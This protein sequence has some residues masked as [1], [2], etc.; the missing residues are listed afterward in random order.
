MVIIMYNVFVYGSL[1]KGFGNHGFLSQSEFLGDATTVDSRFRM[2]SLG[3][4]PGVYDVGNDKIKGEIY[5]VNHYTLR[6]LD[7]LESEGSF[8]SRRTF[9]FELSNGQIID[10]YIYILLDDFS[11]SNDDSILDSSEESSRIAFWTSD[12]KVKYI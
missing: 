2:V 1:K 10:S 7:R 12:R 8:Y 11:G 9:S 4:F 6:N 3:S 5:S